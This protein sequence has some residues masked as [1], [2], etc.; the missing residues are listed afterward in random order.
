MLVFSGVCRHEETAKIK[1]NT[2]LA[3]YCKARGLGTL[4]TGV[5]AEG[6]QDNREII[7]A[8]LSFLFVFAGISA[9]IWL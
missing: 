3:V 9:L 4:G 6:R 7:E 2:T 5:R 8:H 1:A